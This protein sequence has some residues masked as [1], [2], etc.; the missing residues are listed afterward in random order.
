MTRLP[1]RA[2][3]APAVLSHSG[4]HRLLALAAVLVASFAFGADAPGPYDWPQWRG[5]DRT[6]ISK[7]TGLLRKWPAEGPP[8]VYTA[9]DL[10]GGYGSPVVAAGK[11]YGA[12]KE[13]AK[14]YVWCLNEK[15][16]SEVWKK[17]FASPG[18]VG[19]DEGPRCTPTYHVD[20]KLGAVVY[21]IGV[22]GELV[23]MKASNGEK[24][25]AKN[26]S[27]DFGGRMMS[28]WGYSESPLI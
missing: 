3:A 22:G 8:K 9:K 21:A 10:G 26:F 7:E 16:G 5:P 27:K 12:G 14:E 6:A 20:P 19:Y 25:W 1:F 18:R 11:I 13:G 23:C 17:E 4:L 28:G 24:V 2:D 15:D